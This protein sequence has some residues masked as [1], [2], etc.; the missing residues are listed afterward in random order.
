MARPKKKISD[1]ALS[2]E[3]LLKKAVTLFEIPYD[4][5]EER[6]ASRPSLRSVADEM[7]TTI[8]R[9]RKLL[10]TA[11]YYS[12]DTSRA[13][14][15]LTNAGVGAEEIMERMSLSRASVNS[16]LRT[17]TWPSISTRQL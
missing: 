5:R 17:K 16:Y 2:M 4:D 11:G 7:G 13:V 10:I 12:T 6:D 3:E 14:Q 8:L 1:P 9:V 15:S